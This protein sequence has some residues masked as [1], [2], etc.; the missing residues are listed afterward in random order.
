MLKKITYLTK[1][2]VICLC[3]FSICAAAEL[4]ILPLKK[5]NL[6]KEIQEKKISKDILKPKKKPKLKT[7][8]KIEQNGEE[9]LPK[10]K[11]LLTK[12]EKNIVDGEI[13][14][15][16]KPL[17]AKKEINKTKEKSKYYKK[18]DFELAKIAIRSM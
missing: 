17:V 18:R 3:Y 8:S 1:I 12:K 14:P 2:V 4:K 13:I 15:K 11:P 6:S 16:S 7:I 5:P 10:N 9:I